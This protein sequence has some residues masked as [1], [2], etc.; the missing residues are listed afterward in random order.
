M[1][2]GMELQNVRRDAILAELQKKDAD[3]VPAN[4]S[5]PPHGDKP[6]AATLDDDTNIM[7][8]DPVGQGTAPSEENTPAS[9]TLP[10]RETNAPGTDAVA[11]TEGARM[12]AIAEAN[13]QKAAL[14]YLL[15]TR[16]RQAL[17]ALVAAGDGFSQALAADDLVK[18]NTMLTNEPNAL[19]ALPNEF[20]SDHQWSRL[21]ERLATA[22]KAQKAKDL[23]EARKQFLPFSTAMVELIRQL[24]KDDPDFA[25]LKI[26]H[27]PMAPKPGLWM[28]AKGPLR[29]P[30]YGAEMLTCGEE[31]VK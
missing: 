10:H 4:P 17:V 14:P 26:Y 3:A 2:P 28:Q 1:S 19:L 6:A 25:K 31:V 5:P 22:G 15:T 21:I 20:S 27:C 18:Y 7:S 23:A 8:L 13:K 12:A 9:D 30:F 24:P 16:Q 29:N 11:K